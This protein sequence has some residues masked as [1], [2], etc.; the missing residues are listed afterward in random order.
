MSH[1][2]LDVSCRDDY[3]D[4]YPDHIKIELTKD[5]VDRMIELRNAVINTKAYRISIFQNADQYFSTSMDIES[6]DDVLVDYDEALDGEI[7]NITEHYIRWNAVLRHTD[8]K[9]ESGEISFNLLLEIHKVMNA[10]LK[11]LPLLIADLI[12]DEA[13]EML[14][15]RLTNG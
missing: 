10:P 1:L 15:E 9:I 4:N 6:G 2:I 14:S 3:T 13:K 8:I 7:L 12:S 5:F 11:E